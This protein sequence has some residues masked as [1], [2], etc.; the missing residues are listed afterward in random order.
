M[1]EKESRFARAYLATMDMEKAAKEI[2]GKAPGELPE[3]YAEAIRVCRQNLSDAI[4]REDI[5]RRLVQIGFRSGEECME[6]LEGNTERL[7]LSL[8]SELKRNS[9][10]TVEIK[11][12][13]RVAVLK[14]LLELLKGEE[15][16]GA[17]AFL[18]SLQAEEGQE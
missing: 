10:G 18:R 16:D 12:I 11:L 3:K 8:V 1:T 5:I 17:E 6:I 7:D 2:G 13:D 15:G 4:C 14:L 9:N